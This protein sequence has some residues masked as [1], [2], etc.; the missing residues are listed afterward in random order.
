MKRNL[1]FLIFL[2][3]ALFLANGCGF[4][5]RGKIVASRLVTKA[6]AENVLGVPLRLD[7][8]VA[9][10]DITRCLYLNADENGFA[11]LSVIVQTFPTI[12]QI[13]DSEEMFKKVKADF[14]RVETLENIG[15]SAWSASSRNGRSRLIFVRKNN[16][17]FQLIADGEN[18]DEAT[19]DKLKSLAVRV[20]EQ[21]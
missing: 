9:A 7:S 14:G 2:L 20:A 18:I 13:A 3:S 1:Y 15:D 4:A 21:L 17:G 5:G 12:E 11:E 6:D 8:D 16:V 19:F 10:D